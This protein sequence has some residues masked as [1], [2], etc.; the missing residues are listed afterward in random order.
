MTL[1][2]TGANFKATGIIYDSLYAEAK[3][4]SVGVLGC[5]LV[6]AV[7]SALAKASGKSVVINEQVTTPGN[8]VS[9]KLNYI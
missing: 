1:V 9:V 8:S 4:K 3:P 6:S 2:P 5:P 7:A